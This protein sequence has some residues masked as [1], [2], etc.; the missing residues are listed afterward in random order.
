MAVTPEHTP[1]AMDVDRAGRRPPIKC[2]DHGKID[3]TARFCQ[4]KRKIQEAHIEKEEEPKEDF[5]EES[6]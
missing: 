4:E 6:Q 5:S 2:F 3:H 1:D